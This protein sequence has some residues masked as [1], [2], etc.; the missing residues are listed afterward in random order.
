M[1]VM[2]HNWMELLW[3]HL[4]KHCD[5]DYLL[6]LSEHTLIEQVQSVA[7]AEVIPHSTHTFVLRILLN[8]IVVSQLIDW[9]QTLHESIQITVVTSVSYPY[10]AIGKVLQILVSPYLFRFV[11]WPVSALAHFALWHSGT[12]N[13]LDFILLCVIWSLIW[14]F[15]AR[16]SHNGWTSTIDA[17]EKIPHIFSEQV[18]VNVLLQ[19]I[20]LLLHHKLS[21]Q[22]WV[23]NRSWRFLLKVIVLMRE[24]DPSIDP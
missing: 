9:S 5:L 8:Q 16:A 1:R 23:I 24:L 14:I 4:L 3:H 10:Y 21:F 6:S 22:V 13:W 20:V 15:L 19:L 18:V 12:S 7:E 17:I 2:L 11:S